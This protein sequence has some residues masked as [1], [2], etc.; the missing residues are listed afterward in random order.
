[1]KKLTLLVIATLCIVNV[2]AEKVKVSGTITGNTAPT[3][4]NVQLFYQGNVAKSDLKDGKFD[5]EIEID[6]DGFVELY[7]NSTNFFV[8]ASPKE[9][10][11]LDIVVNTMNDY[12][13]TSINKKDAANQFLSE[14]HKIALGMKKTGFYTDKFK[15]APNAAK[16]FISKVEELKKEKLARVVKK[17][18][19]FE[20]NLKHMFHY[21]YTFANATN[22]NAKEITKELEDLKTSGYSIHEISVPYFRNYFEDLL[23]IKVADK[24]TLYNLDY[25]T[26]KDANLINTVYAEYLVEYS[27][28]QSFTNF[29]FFKPVSQELMLNGAKN[30]DYL[31]YIFANVNS[32]SYD[33]FR[34][35]FESKLA[36]LKEIE[37]KGVEKAF[38]F[39]F[40]DKDGKAYGLD[41]FKGKMLLIDCW[42][43][44]CGPC[45][46]QIPALKSLEEKYK[47]K[48]INFVSVSLDNS[49]KAWLKA[50]DEED[51]HGYVLH[52][53]GAF[54]N[55]FAKHYG[56]N[57]IPRF[58]LIDANGN[59]INADMPK[60]SEEEA[61][62]NI[63]DV[64]LYDNKVKEIIENH[65]NALHVD[66]LNGK[67][68]H[69][70][71]SSSI[72]GMVNNSDVY[73]TLD[74]TKKTVS[75]PGN[76]ELMKQFFG[77]AGGDPTTILLKDGI[78]YSKGEEKPEEGT[79][80]LYGYE[81][82]YL[83]NAGAK[84]TMNKETFD[85]EDNCYVLDCNFK[86]KEVTYY[87][88]KETNLLKKSVLRMDA[89]R[90]SGGGKFTLTYSYDNYAEVNG[91]IY[92]K[93]YSMNG[94][95]TVVVSSFEV[96]KA[97]QNVFKL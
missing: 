51:L 89:G 66:Q 20:K 95:F 83:A 71:E 39:E 58:L 77:P 67:M 94:M 57:S 15:D 34:K 19:E 2:F 44:W 33:P 31:E 76:P 65:K 69:V 64:R 72:M 86:G 30:K 91:Q 60:P 35:D 38:N 50:V 43:S 47:G 59:V 82:V 12:S 9:D 29:M 78:S 41:H 52:A 1:M 53:P 37:N 92:L 40:L 62:R 48:D 36:A 88:S 81:L 22:L 55:E 87:I 28:E 56:I 5:M 74:N 80:N 21:M 63:I 17:Y 27:P 49:K 45:R 8:Y 46:G 16:K 18:P 42:A 84:F 11:N 96:I 6:R 25:D 54:K 75:T 73:A 79:P 10:L 13:I 90:R 85:N 68:F 24:L 26:Q 23:K 61:V 97:D 4:K 93:K 70:K 14:M 32:K 7:L 3:F